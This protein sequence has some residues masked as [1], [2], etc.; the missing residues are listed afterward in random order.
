M[1]NINLYMLKD[2][3]LL[4]LKLPDTFIWFKKRKN[5]NKTDFKIC[6]FTVILITAA[7]K[8][9]TIRIGPIF[10]IRQVPVSLILSMSSLSS[11]SD[12]TGFIIVNLN[13]IFPSSSAC[14]I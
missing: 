2:S 10:Q 4:H 1:I 14:T 5:L 8:T 9:L 13:Q 12:V 6:V 7:V 3:L 11:F